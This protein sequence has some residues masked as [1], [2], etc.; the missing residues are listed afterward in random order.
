MPNIKTAY[1]MA[2]YNHPDI[3]SKSYRS[4]ILNRRAHICRTIWIFPMTAVHSSYVMVMIQPRYQKDITISREYPYTLK[5]VSDPAC[6]SSSKSLRCFHSAPLLQW[7]VV[8]LWRLSASKVKT[9]SQSGQQVWEQLSS[10]R[11]IIKSRIWH[12]TE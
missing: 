10:S 3:R 2:K 12:Y 11:I 1:R 7:A 5:G 6:V 4:S 8:G 9:M